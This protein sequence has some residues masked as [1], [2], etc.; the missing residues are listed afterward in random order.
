MKNLRLKGKGP[1]T[2]PDFEWVR[3]SPSA[4][5]YEK[6][7]KKSR[8]MRRLLLEGYFHFA[9]CY[10]GD[11]QDEKGIGNFA[12]IVEIGETK[13][14]N[15]FLIHDKNNAREVFNRIDWEDNLM[16]NH[17]VPQITPEMLIEAYEKNIT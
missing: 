1:T 13:S 15:Y 3:G 9:F 4:D 10:W 6:N 5:A 14:S 12:K 11:I 7:D 17:G 16:I 2:H 8:R